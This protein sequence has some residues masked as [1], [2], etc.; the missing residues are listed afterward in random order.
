MYISALVESDIALLVPLLWDDRVYEH[1]GGRHSDAD[2]LS[3]SLQRALDASRA[4]STSELWLN[5]S[6]RLRDGDHLI[7]RLEATV[8]DGIVEVAFLLG[9]EYWGHG[10]A[11][12]GLSWLHQELARVCPGARCWATTLPE[13]ARSNRLLLSC[14]YVRVNPAMAP[15]LLTYDD[16]DWVYCATEVA[17]LFSG[18]AA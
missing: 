5:Y 4:E 2:V 8:H 1:I 7:G 9:V 14:G 10:Y 13:N 6:M 11:K 12:E 15:Q 16:G 3:L 18:F 17:P